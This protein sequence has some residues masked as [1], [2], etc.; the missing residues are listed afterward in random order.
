MQEKFGKVQRSSSSKVQDDAGTQ[1]STSSKVKDDAGTA[2]ASKVPAKTKGK[3]KPAATKAKAKADGGAAAA[4][5]QA[6]DHD[7]DEELSELSDIGMSMEEELQAASA[8]LEE[9][10]RDPDNFLDRLD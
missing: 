6:E 10:Y 2:K 7:A 5:S 4:A 1:A 3:A 9:M 8:M